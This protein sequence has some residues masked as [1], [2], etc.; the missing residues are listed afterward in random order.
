MP[1]KT[2]KPASERRACFVVE[3][4]FLAEHAR[5][6]M[7]SEVPASA[8]RLLKTALV[9]AEVDETARAILDGHRTLVGDSSV[10]LTAV[11]EKKKVTA[12]YRKTLLFIYA[13]RVRIKNAWYRPATEVKLDVASAEAAS[14]IVSRYMELSGDVLRPVGTESAD[15]LELLRMWWRARMEHGA[16]GGQIAVELRDGVTRTRFVL[17]E[18]C[19]EPPFWWDELRTP[20]EAFDQY[21]DHRRPVDEQTLCMEDFT[22]H[23]YE[24]EE[25]DELRE[26]SEET[27]VARAAREAAEQIQNDADDARRAAYIAGLREKI[28]EQAGDDLIDLKIPGDTDDPADDVFPREHRE[29]VVKVPRAPF[30]HWLL[31]RLDKA[32]LAPPWT[33]VSPSGL[34]LQMDDEC[35][36][37]W[38]IGAGLDLHADY[39]HGSN[40]HKAAFELGYDIT[41]RIA[42]V[43][44]IPLSR[45]NGEVVHGIVGQSIA[46]LADL[47]P[48]QADLVLA[49]RAVVTEMGGELAHL[50]IVARESGIPLMLVKNARELFPSGTYLRVDPNG[51]VASL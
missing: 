18:P 37:D 28:L 27:A 44:A 25:A 15:A 3:G 42:N 51:D 31:R 4:A 30:L 23:E 36:T 47:R 11:A 6:L 7:L 43:N 34:K 35:H 5:R 20:E 49:S 50:A 16:M 39:W 45:G 41:T 1:T 40:A 26:S 38:M 13:G 9:G 32:H 46:V 24:I 33:P 2:K 48:S 8:W 21:Q 14:R 17:F 10:G 22:G 19:G 29:R 12:S